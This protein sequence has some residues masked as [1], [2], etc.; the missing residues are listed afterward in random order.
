MYLVGL[1]KHI[2]GSQMCFGNTGVDLL[3][4]I[5]SRRHRIHSVAVLAHATADVATPLLLSAT[6][7]V[8][9]LKTFHCHASSCKRLIVCSHRSSPWYW[10]QQAEML[11]RHAS[12]CQ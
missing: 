7:K 3:E 8:L 11:A 12:L 9:H 5:S 10:L 6:L 4:E 1:V 2:P